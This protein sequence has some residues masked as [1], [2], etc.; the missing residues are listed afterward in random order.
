MNDAQLLERAFKA[1]GE[2]VTRMAEKAEV[3]RQVVQHWRRRGKLPSW[4]RAVVAKIAAS[5]Q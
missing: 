4:R 3:S 5:L 2:N 1:C